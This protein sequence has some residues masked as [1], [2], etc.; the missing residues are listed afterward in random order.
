MSH[1]LVKKLSELDSHDNIGD[2]M[3][4]RSMI[5]GLS[6]LTL[7]APFAIGTLSACNGDDKETPHKS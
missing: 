5:K 3:R 2:T 4:R 7:L 6:S 1:S